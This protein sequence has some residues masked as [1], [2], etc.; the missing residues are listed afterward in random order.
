MLNFLF[1]LSNASIE[2]SKTITITILFNSLQSYVN[3]LVLSFWLIYASSFPSGDVDTTNNSLI[4]SKGNPLVSGT[5][6]KINIQE[7]ALIIQKNP[8]TPVVP[9]PLFMVGNRNMINMFAVHVIITHRAKQIPLTLVGKISEH[10]MFATAPNT[11]LKAQKNTISPT[12]E[13]PPWTIP[14]E[15]IYLPKQL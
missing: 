4:T 2:L 7:T 6:R 3:H 1:V 10:K 8:K 9:K 5:L 12:I 15:A 11:I 14:I 13:I